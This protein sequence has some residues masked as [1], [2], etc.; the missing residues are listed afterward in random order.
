MASDLPTLSPTE[1]LFD[2]IPVFDD[3]TFWLLPFLD[4]KSSYRRVRGPDVQKRK[5]NEDESSKTGV[6]PKDASNGERGAS[7][8]AKFSPGHGRD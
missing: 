5:E 3:S 1:H 2:S 8:D 6:L 7:P 4:I